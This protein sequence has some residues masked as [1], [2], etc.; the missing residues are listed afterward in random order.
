[1]YR[2]GHWGNYWKRACGNVSFRLGGELGENKSEIF[3]KRLQSNSFGMR[4][5]EKRGVKRNNADRV[6]GQTV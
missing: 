3:Q 1:M 5:E 4:V 6:S 2:S